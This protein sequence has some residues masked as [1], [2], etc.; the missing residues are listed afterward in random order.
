[1]LF[2]I[3]FD[4]FEQKSYI[5]ANKKPTLLLR[6][7][8]F[9]FFLVILL[10]INILNAQS[11]DK[12]QSLSSELK[13]AFNSKTEANVPFDVANKTTIMIKKKCHDLRKNA[14]ATY[15]AGD[16]CAAKLFYEEILKYLPNDL[17]AK[18]RIKKCVNFADLTPSRMV[19][20]KGG[21][22]YMG[23]FHARGNEA[24][25]HKLHIDGFYMNKYEVTN[26]EFAEFLN[27][28]YLFIN[29]INSVIDLNGSFQNEHCRIYH[30]GSKFMVEL[31]YENHPVA[32]VNW[33]GAEAYAK[34]KGGRL[35]TEAEWEFAATGGVYSRNCKYA[36]SNNVEQVGWHCSN[37]GNSL[38]I[39]GLKRANELGI[40]DLSGNIFEWCS[41][42]YSDVYYRNSPSKNPKGA[43]SGS[44]KVMRGSS[45]S[46]LPS[47]T[48]NT[49]R[50]WVNPEFS[51]SY[52]G[53]RIVKD[54]PAIK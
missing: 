50:S 34:W 4:F 13:N 53:F 29:D 22:F 15:R 54:L 30:T 39:V 10:N 3:S 33:Y 43:I 26:S 2:Y 7:K 16:Y 17:V 18:K 1:M 24:P 42:W 36:G 28:N 35:P 40:Y 9:Y 5:A 19:Y 38:Q 8:T 52:I 45:Y 46:N 31:G 27:R 25:R 49:V 23:T 21:T 11:T 47:A 44:Y 48:Q 14:D 20:V 6:M 51:V 32:F 41:D 37:S 12:I